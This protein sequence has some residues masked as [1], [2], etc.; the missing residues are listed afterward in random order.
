MTWITLWEGILEYVLDGIYVVPPYADLSSWEEISV[1]ESRGVG[2]V[3]D[4]VVP[5]WHERNSSTCRVGSIFRFQLGVG[6]IR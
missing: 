6:C 5:E 1:S 4:T 3:G 2:F